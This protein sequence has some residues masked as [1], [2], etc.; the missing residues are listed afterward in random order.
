M[1]EAVSVT[2]SVRPTGRPGFIDPF[3]KVILA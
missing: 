3:T 2:Y 1:A